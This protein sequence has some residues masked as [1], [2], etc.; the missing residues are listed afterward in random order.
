MRTFPLSIKMGCMVPQE[1]S[2]L[3]WHDLFT[4]NMTGCTVGGFRGLAGS[5][6]A[7]IISF[8]VRWKEAAWVCS[9]QIQ[10]FSLFSLRLVE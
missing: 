4:V 8:I 3:L 5:S 2:S 6:A 7:C 10:C 9:V 1:M